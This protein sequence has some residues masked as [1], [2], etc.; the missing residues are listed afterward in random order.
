MQTSPG[1]LARVT[2]F[3]A[4][5]GVLGARTRT[6]GYLISLLAKEAT[7]YTAKQSHS[8]SAAKLTNLRTCESGIGVDWQDV[9]SGCQLV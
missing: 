3:L 9:A 1:K 6:S 5:I 8:R 7:G 4:S 2:Y